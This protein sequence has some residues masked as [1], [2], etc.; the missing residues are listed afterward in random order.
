[1]FGLLFELIKAHFNNGQKLSQ[2][3]REN[4]REQ[5]ISWPETIQGEVWHGLVSGG[6]G[7]PAQCS[8]S[9]CCLLDIQT[10]CRLRVFTPR[11]PQLNEH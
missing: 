7:T 2:N 10:H 6:V 1:L 3:G 8:S 9:V 11:P 5:K 4:T